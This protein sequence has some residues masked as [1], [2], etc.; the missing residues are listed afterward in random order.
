MDRLA[1]EYGSA[2][3]GFDPTILIFG[4]SDNGIRAARESTLNHG[5]RV[6]AELPLAE[7][8]DRLDAQIAVDLVIVDVSFDHGPVLDH[9]FRKI[10]NGAASNRFSSI[11]SISPELADLMMTRI[12]HD[13]VS[14]MV[15]RDSRALDNAVARRLARVQPQLRED[16]P[17]PGVSPFAGPAHGGAADDTVVP[18]VPEGLTA[19]LSDVP[20]SAMTWADGSRDFD[21][22]V[23][24]GIIRARHLRNEFFGARLFADPAWDILLDLMAAR[25]E[26]RS[27]AVSSLCIGAAVPA[28]TALRWIKQLTEIGLLRRVADPLDGRRV[29]IELTGEAIDKLDAYFTALIWG[30]ES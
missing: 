4:D 30:R 25:L 6:A 19:D 21:P 5:G 8:A 22:A 16:D 9:L 29:F 23:I 15:G 13:D 7:G 17:E 12:E 26:R 11:V 18:S 1:G 10:Q 14:V 24:H 3:R 27:V 2:F 28:T 20:E